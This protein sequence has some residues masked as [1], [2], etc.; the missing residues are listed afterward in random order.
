MG[1]QFLSLAMMLAGIGLM[2]YILRRQ[3]NRAANART[4]SNDR[5]AK[6]R[7][8][9][10]LRGSMDELLVQLEQMAREINAQV[11]TRFAKLERAIR[12][13]DDRIARL[14]AASTG[15]PVPI[16][17]SGPPPAATAPVKS[18]H[19]PES[20]AADA[21][22]P[23]EPNHR[24]T[25]RARTGPTVAAVHDASAR[26]T[27]TLASRRPRDP[28]DEA[29]LR[30]MAEQFFDDAPPGLADEDTIAAKGDGAPIPTAS[31]QRAPEP[32]PPRSK[33]RKVSAAPPPVEPDDSPSPSPTGESPLVTPPPWPRSRAKPSS[34][35]GPVDE[36]AGPSA[37]Q[38]EQVYGLADQRRSADQIASQLG[39]P[40]GEVDL[41]LNLRDFR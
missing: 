14:T 1:T 28:Q 39:M 26:R 17:T 21:A 15:Q 4:I 16:P 3:V 32:L 8:Q 22:E 37:E 11:D 27:P 9:R 23:V 25:P 34:D 18:E 38:I 20:P 13:A 5:I 10:E 7:D 24:T 40:V 19:N 36:A 2:M 31:R 30:A 33:P 35:A 6:L 29:T 41:I 12:D